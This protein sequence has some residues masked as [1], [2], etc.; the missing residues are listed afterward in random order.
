MVTALDQ[1]K[2]PL[3]AP[4]RLIRRFVNPVASPSRIFMSPLEYGK[5][6]RDLVRYLHMEGAESVSVSDL[7]P[8]L[9]ETK[10]AHP[11]DSHYFHLGIWAAKRIIR[12]GTPLHVDVGPKVDFISFLTCFTRVIFVDVRAISARVQN[13]ESMQASI[14]ALPFG[15]TSVQSLS[16]LHVAEHV[17]LGRYG[18][19]LDPHG[20]EKAA[21]ELSRVLGVN[22]DLFF[23]VPIGKPKLCFNAHRIYSTRQITRYFHDLE[24]VEFSGVDDKGEYHE[25]LSIDALANSRYA[26]GFFWFKR[27]SESPFYTMN[28]D[29]QEKQNA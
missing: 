22:G 8:C 26:C 10:Y 23:A 12:N 21:R 5:Y 11:F 14:L 28:P 15:D 16:C 25:N 13:L 24:L 17:G 19:P 2:R 20:T 7:Y 27:S 3:R 1:L 4:Y 29:Q 9:Y 6:I 18:D